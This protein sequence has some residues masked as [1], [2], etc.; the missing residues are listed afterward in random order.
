MSVIVE[1][2]RIRLVGAATVED[3]EPLLAALVDHPGHPVDVAD[4]VR[5]HLAVVQLLHAAGRRLSGR[6]E[7]PF[8]RAMAL[9]PLMQVDA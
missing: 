1:A 6:P 2:D 3:A 8:L 7:D 9:G 5:A 4:L